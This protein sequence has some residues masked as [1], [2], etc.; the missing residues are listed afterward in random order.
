MLKT[1]FIMVQL[2]IINH[3]DMQ[4]LETT[5]QITNCCES[6]KEK[7][8]FSSIF[9]ANCHFQKQQ[10]FVVTLALTFRVNFNLSA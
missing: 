1:F 5:R 10:H 8:Q 2:Q 4:Q 3:R 7:M 6:A 9:S